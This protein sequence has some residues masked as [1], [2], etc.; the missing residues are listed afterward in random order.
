MSSLV[1]LWFLNSYIR[2]LVFRSAEGKS[3]ELV[4][5]NWVSPENGSSRREDVGTHRIFRFLGRKVHRKPWMWK[6]KNGTSDTF[7]V[8]RAPFIYKRKLDKQIHL[9]LSRKIMQRGMRSF[10]GC[11]MRRKH[12]QKRSD[13]DFCS[14]DLERDVTHLPSFLW[15]NFFLSLFH[16]P[17]KWTTN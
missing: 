17:R 9:W 10:C 7:P 13:C 6:W 2:S 16:E 11:R 8:C 14:L 4:T 3:L 5:P 15:S 1:C 12:E